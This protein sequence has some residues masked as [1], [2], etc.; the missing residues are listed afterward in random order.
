MSTPAPDR[1]TSILVYV[2]LFVN[3]AFVIGALVWLE[4]DSHRPPMRADR[5]PDRQREP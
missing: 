1:I 3:V 2:V 4:W 5:L